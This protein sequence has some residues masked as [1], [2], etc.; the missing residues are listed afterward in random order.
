VRKVV[1]E[2]GDEA[3]VEV[4]QEYTVPLMRIKREPAVLQD[5]WKRIDGVWYHVDDRGVMFRK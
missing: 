2:Q 4:Y 3:V 1:S 5:K